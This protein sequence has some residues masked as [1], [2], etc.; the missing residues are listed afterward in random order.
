MAQNKVEY[1]IQDGAIFTFKVATG[2]TLKIGE[3][4]TLTGDRTVGKAASTATAPAIGVVYG[5]TVGKD[6]VNVG[7]VGNE[8][9]VVSVVVFKPFVYLEAGAAV[10]AGTRLVSDAQGKAIAVSGVL[11]PFATAVTGATAAGQ[12]II[13]YLN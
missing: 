5:G 2:Q 7:F 3:I 9:D 4:V 1:H 12:K 6:G 11:L 13:A 10:T 8:G